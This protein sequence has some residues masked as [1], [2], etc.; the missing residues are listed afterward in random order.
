MAANRARGIKILPSHFDLNMPALRT[1]TIMPRRHEVFRILSD[2]VGLPD[3]TIGDNLGA[4]RVF[5]DAETS[6]TDKLN[7]FIPRIDVAWAIFSQHFQL[8]AIDRETVSGKKS[9]ARKLVDNE[10]FL[11]LLKLISP[12][13]VLSCLGHDASSRHE[14]VVVVFPSLPIPLGALF[15][16]SHKSGVFIKK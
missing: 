12:K 7:I 2:A 6:V 9:K 10:L 1:L 11:P 13:S 15:E 16:M 3:A 14:F 5:A 4:G 8:H